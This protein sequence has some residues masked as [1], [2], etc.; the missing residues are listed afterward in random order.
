MKFRHLITAAAISM[1]PLAAQAASLVVPAVGT[2]AGAN[3]SQWQSELTLHSVAP[4]VVTLTLMLHQ[5][6]TII[7]PVTL[8]LQPRETLSIEDVA[9]TKFGLTSGAGAL[10]IDV[11]DRDAKSLAV[12]SRTFNTTPD[13]VFG[14]DIPAIN[15]AA[16]SVAGDVTAL[17]AASDA[18]TSRFNFGVYAI[19]A[20]NVRWEL[21]RANGTIAAT[22]DLSY[23]AGRHV[24][25]NG[26]TQLLLGAQSADNDTIHARVLSGRAIFY[27]SVINATGDPGFVPGIRTREDIAIQF[28]GVDLDENGTVDIADAN[29]DGVL[30]APVT[31][32][33]SLFPSY[34]RLVASGEFGEAVQFEVLSAPNVDA[35]LLDDQGTLRVAAG[36]NV[37]EKT[38]EIRVRATSGTSSA[39]LVIPMQYR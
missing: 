21:V 5:H 38:G 34:F 16:A 11:A 19:E 28:A 3:N 17:P 35:D 37:R 2:G 24:Q 31:M 7:G 33:K 20:T 8:T 36:G 6:T 32:T 15:I 29:G 26:G 14:Q 27:G 10:V 22:K 23:G 39:I 9:R 12:T 13:G 18:A 4:R 30:D 25:H 1:M